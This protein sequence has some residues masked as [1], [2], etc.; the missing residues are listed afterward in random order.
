[1]SGWFDDK[2]RAAVSAALDAQ[3]PGSAEL[4]AV[5]YV[6]RLLTALDHDPPRIWAAPEGSGQDWLELG[7]WERAAWAE[8][9]DE[10]RAAYAR[11][12]A[13]DP[14]DADRRMLHDH[15]CEA[16]FGDPAYGGNRDGAAWR[17]IGFPEPMFPP[18]RQA[19]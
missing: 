11:V 17:R 4:G 19:P 12:V 3:V 5:G 13:G 14:T 1:V 8:R 2:A 10:M 7:A 9:I 18:A 15:A 16:T 6:E